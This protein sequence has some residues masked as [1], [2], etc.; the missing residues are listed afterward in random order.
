VTL[1]RCYLYREKVVVPTVKQTEAGFY[2]DSQPV[3]V[4]PMK[5]RQS[6][7]SELVQALTKENEMVPTPD[8]SQEAGSVILDKLGLQKWSSFEKSAVMYTIMLGV[9]YVTVYASGRGTDGMWSEASSKQR[10]FHP[11]L[12]KE[13]I[14]DLLIEEMLHQPEARAERFS[15]APIPKSSK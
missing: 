12:S 14:A 9:R 15:L 7:H 8:A 4:H 3:E 10:Q 2:V 13:A 6:L 11:Q 1:I 5:D